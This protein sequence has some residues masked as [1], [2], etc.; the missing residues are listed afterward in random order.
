MILAFIIASV[1]A[2][3]EEELDRGRACSKIIG[4]MFV[5]DI[6]QIRAICAKKPHLDSRAL[7]NKIFV[8]LVDYCYENAPFSVLQPVVFF[9]KKHSWKEFAEYL[10]IDEDKYIIPE[11]LIITETQLAFRKNILDTE[12]GI[13]F[14]GD[15]KDKEE[16]L[17]QYHKKMKD[18]GIKITRK[19]H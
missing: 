9:M 2:Y 15:P 16:T 6:S 14:I 11:D 12:G 17:K 10:K 18:E 13:R 7:E 8:D 3:T 4:D 1:L 19:E 5:K